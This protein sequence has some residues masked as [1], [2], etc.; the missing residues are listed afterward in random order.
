MDA[1][2]FWLIAAAL[3]AAGE[4][5]TTSFYLFPFALGAAGGGIVSL[6]TGEPVPSVAFALALTTISFLFL[7]PIAQRH[8][9]QP[10]HMRTGADRLIGQ[11]AT[12]LELV[13]GG[14]TPGSIKLDGEVWTARPYEPGRTFAQGEQVEVIEIQGATALVAD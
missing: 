2:V 9:M 10:P 14:Q 13:D 11:R 3:L 6:A 7:R 4:I 8:L 12:V 5:A 1:W